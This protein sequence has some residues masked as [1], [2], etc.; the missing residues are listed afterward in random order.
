MPGTVSLEG[1]QTHS[2]IALHLCQL[3]FYTSN[4]EVVQENLLLDF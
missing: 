3:I 2:L 1:A 4:R